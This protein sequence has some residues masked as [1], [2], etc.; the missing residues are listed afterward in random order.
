VS[1]L[2]FTILDVAAEQFSATPRLIARIGI[3]TGDDEPIQAIALR[4]QIRIEPLRRSYSDDEAGGLLDLFGPRHRWVNT[5]RTFLWQHSTA[6]VQGFTGVTEV[7][8][9][10]ECTYDF[11]VTASKYLHALHDGAV[12]LL[13]LFSGTVFVQG[14]RGFSVS[15]VSWECEA[16]HE[17]PVAVWKDLIRMHYPNAGWVRLGHDTVA[18]LAAYKSARGMLDFEDAITTLL[19]EEPEISV[20]TPQPEE[21]R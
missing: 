17:M 4:C 21:V 19:A 11:E 1:D 18:A 9:S 3:T 16:Q 10:L 6:M 8:L 15:Q 13:F 5:Q 7:A 20:P 14:E 2:T 12:P